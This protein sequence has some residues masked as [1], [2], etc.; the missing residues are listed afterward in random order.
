[1]SSGIEELSTRHTY[2]KVRRPSLTNLDGEL[3]GGVE[4]EARDRHDHKLHRPEGT[5]N[6]LC[7]YHLTILAGESSDE[8]LGS[9]SPIDDLSARSGGEAYHR[10]V[11]DRNSYINQT[12]PQFIKASNG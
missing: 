8:E 3:I 5:G 10:L 12:F 1:M 4:R 2:K 6:I 11:I 7:S 9:V